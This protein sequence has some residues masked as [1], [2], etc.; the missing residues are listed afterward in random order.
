MANVDCWDIFKFSPLPRFD[1]E[2]WGPVHLK[3]QNDTRIRPFQMHFDE[4]V[5][6]AFLCFEVSCFLFMF[7]ILKNI[8]LYTIMYLN[9]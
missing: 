7:H 1:H 4:G 2:W 8:Y 3:Y 6:H 5:S 9:Y